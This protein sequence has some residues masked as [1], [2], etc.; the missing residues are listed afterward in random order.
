M[1]KIYENQIIECNC[2]HCC[3][4]TVEVLSHIEPI[5]YDYWEVYNLATTKVHRVIGDLLGKKE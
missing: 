2:S 1:S 4:S 3:G 5:A